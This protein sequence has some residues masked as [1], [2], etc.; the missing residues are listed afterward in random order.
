MAHN[1]NGFNCVDFSIEDVSQVTS[2]ITAYHVAF[3][4]DEDTRWNRPGHMRLE[5]CHT[6]QMYVKTSP[7]LS[8]I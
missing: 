6:V 8:G 5:T 1:K 3:G 7:I 4:S 2:L